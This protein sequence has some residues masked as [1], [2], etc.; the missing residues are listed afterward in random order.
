MKRGQHHQRAM[1]IWLLALLVLSGCQQEQQTQQLRHWLAQAGHEN[2][3]PTPPPEQLAALPPAQGFHADPYMVNGTT[4]PFGEH[5]TD[6]LSQSSVDQ[7]QRPPQRTA[8]QLL[9]NFA[10]DSIQMIGSLAGGEKRHAVVKV[11]DKLYQ[12]SPGDYLGQRFGMIEH[13]SENAIVLEELVPDA[14]GAWIVHRARIA[15]E[16]NP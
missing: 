10:L 15:M 5:R 11:A 6:Q 16:N 3:P 4:S 1:S 14:D 8:P 13:I 9:E 2:L 12:V 7:N